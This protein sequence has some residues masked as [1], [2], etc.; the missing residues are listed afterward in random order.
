[1]T[2]QLQCETIR[3]QCR[4]FLYL[5]GWSGV[6]VEH[7]DELNPYVAQITKHGR[8]YKFSDPDPNVIIMQLS[9]LYQG[10][11]IGANASRKA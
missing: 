8:L 2:R 9:K 6:F 1:M 7:E 10:A 4:S 3:Q 11:R 5:N